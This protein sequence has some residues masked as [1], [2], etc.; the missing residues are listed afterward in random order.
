MPTV[1][2]RI[3]L[4][5]AHLEDNCENKHERL[6]FHY[7]LDHRP[8]NLGEGKPR[9]WV[10]FA[11]GRHTRQAARAALRT[12]FYGQNRTDGNR[13]VVGLLL[14]MTLGRFAVTMAAADARR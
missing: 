11:T 3:L 14:T 13:S 10:S 6:A 5:W 2:R 12:A 9:A 1:P 7:Y 8:L 4:R